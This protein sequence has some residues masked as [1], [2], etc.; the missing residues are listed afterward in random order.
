M[1]R[2]GRLA[3]RRELATFNFGGRGLGAAR[4]WARKLDLLATWASA[5]AEKGRPVAALSNKFLLA[6]AD[7]PNLRTWFPILSEYP[8]PP[9]QISIAGAGPD[10]KTE[11]LLKYSG[12]VPFT[13][14][15]WRLPNAIISDPLVSFTVAQGCPRCSKNS[16]AF[17]GLG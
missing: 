15:P 10:L 7:L 8:L 13:F 14:E 9:V 2:G 12:R 5:A 6:D 16:R 1:Q 4:L 3:T 17:S 11:V